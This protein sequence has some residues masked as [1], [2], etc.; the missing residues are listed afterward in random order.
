MKVVFFLVSVTKGSHFPL[1]GLSHVL[2]GVPPRSV[3]ALLP[4]ITQATTHQICQKFYSTFYERK[5]IAGGSWAN[6]NEVSAVVDQSAGQ[7]RS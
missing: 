4:A 5:L 2:L 1:D 7:P 6:N 3:P